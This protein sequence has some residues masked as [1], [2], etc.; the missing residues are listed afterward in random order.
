[1][2]KL[3]LGSAVAVA[4]LTGCGEEKKESTNATET[5]ALLEAVVR[6][7]SAGSVAPTATFVITDST[8]GLLGPKTSQTLFSSC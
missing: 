7:F 2:R 1:M 6:S 5:L 8:I 4:L 3:L